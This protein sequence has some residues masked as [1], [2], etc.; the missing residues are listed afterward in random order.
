MIIAALFVI[1]VI[2][3][4]ESPVGEPWDSIADVA[5]WAIWLAFVTEAVVMLAVVPNRRQWLR[6]HPLEVIVIMFTPPFLPATLQSLR[7]LRLARMARLVP[8]LRL[9]PRLF[10]LEG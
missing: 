9:G 3:I 8:L 2:V 1:P 6:T 5:N 4:E 7:V 10:S